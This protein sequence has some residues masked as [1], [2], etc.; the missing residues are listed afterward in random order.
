MG[1][2]SKSRSASKGVASK[3]WLRWAGAASVTALLASFPGLAMAQS[4]Q[5]GEAEPALTDEVVVTGIRAGIESSISAKHAAHAWA[6]REAAASNVPA[7]GSETA[8]APA[9]TT[10]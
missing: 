6:R 3:G 5:P 4:S 9:Q 7:Q 2:N 8:L 10:R 1:E